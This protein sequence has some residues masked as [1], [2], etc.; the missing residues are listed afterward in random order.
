MRSVKHGRISYG[1]ARR[2][3][4]TMFY[5]NAERLKPAAA[6]K[7]YE[8]CL[9]QDLPAEKGMSNDGEDTVLRSNLCQNVE[10][11]GLLAS[12]VQR[13]MLLSL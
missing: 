2:V 10:A 13:T 11:L 3:A 4:K 7:F 12:N 1:T 9:R 8:E 6:K 5:P